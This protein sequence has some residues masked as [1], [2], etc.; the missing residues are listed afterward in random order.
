MKTA[1]K[2][3]MEGKNV[4][5]ISLPVRIFESRSTIERICDNWAFMPIY[6]RKAT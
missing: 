3:L 1:G 6:I 5:A 4:V 2:T